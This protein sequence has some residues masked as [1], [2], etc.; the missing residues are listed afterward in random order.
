VN[1]VEVKSSSGRT[2]VM[3]VT[4]TRFYLFAGD[5][6]LEVLFAAYN[7]RKVRSPPSSFCMVKVTCR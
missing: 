2:V 3:A 5:S 4:P 6:H 7:S 1:T